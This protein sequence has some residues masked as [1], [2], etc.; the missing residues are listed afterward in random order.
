VALFTRAWIEINNILQ[1]G[2]KMAMVALFTRAW[3]EIAMEHNLISG[4]I[5]SPSSRGRG[6]KLIIFCKMGIKW[7]WS[8][9]SRGRGLKLLWNII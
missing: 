3:I 9:S 1:N 6:L 7:R 5:R 8:P 4:L 2:H